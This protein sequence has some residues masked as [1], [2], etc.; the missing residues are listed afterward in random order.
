MR[1]DRGY[2]PAYELAPVVRRETLNANSDIAR[3][4]NALASALTT[5]GITRL[6]AQVEIEGRS[7]SDVAAEFLESAGLPRQ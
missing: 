1:D 7:L 6:N 3:Q 5:S 4:L 2:F